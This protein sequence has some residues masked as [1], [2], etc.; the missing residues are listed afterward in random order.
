MIA[1]DDEDDED[2]EDFDV[3]RQS[4]ILL[5][6]ANSKGTFHLARYRVGNA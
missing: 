1:V 5:P 2:D 4:D 6:L 3:E